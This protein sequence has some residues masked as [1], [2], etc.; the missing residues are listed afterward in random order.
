MPLY[1]FKNHVTPLAENILNSLLS[2]Q[3]FVLIYTGSQIDSKTGSGVTENSIANYTYAARFTLTGVTEISRV[4]LE[5]DKDGDG[6]DLVVQIRDSDFNPD[7]SN[8]GT[9][10]KQVVVPKEFI[11]A[12]AAYWSIPIDLTGLTAGNYYWLVVVKAGDATNKVDWIGEADQDASYPVYYRAGDT[13]A[14]TAGNALHFKVYSG[15]SGDLI[16]GIYGVNGYTTV[17]YSGEIVSKVYRYLP[18]SDT[19][20]GGIRDVIT[21]TW[22]GEYLKKGVIS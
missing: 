12:S 3:D 15:E 14:W 1:A 21:Y 5:L 6:A 4:E 11:P 20:A 18:P 8:D 10:L 19:T 22:D 2:L 16:H 9:V 7:G 13:G 17:E